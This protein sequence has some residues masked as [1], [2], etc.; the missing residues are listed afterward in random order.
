MFKKELADVLK[1]TGW[2]L[3][4][5]GL[6]PGPLILLH[7][8]SGS[9]LGV[10]VSVFQEGLSV[11]SLF[12]GAS[13]FG[14]ERRQR[15][16]EYPLSFPYSRYS[17]LARLV[18]P[19]LI[20]LIALIITAWLIN[21]RWGVGAFAL[22]PLAMAIVY[23]LPLFLISLSLSTLIENFIAL[24]LISLIGWCG[25]G[26]AIFRLLWGQRVTVDI[27][28][29]PVFAV[30][31]PGPGF[32]NTYRPITIFFLQII[33]PLIPFIFAL[34]ISFSRFDIRRSAAFVKRYFMAFVSSS[35]L[36]ALIALIGQATIN[37]T[38]RVFHLTKDLK[39]VEW[40]E[41]LKIIRIHENGSTR[42]TLLDSPILRRPCDD[43][44]FLY[45]QDNN[46]N[47]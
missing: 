47:L 18:G 23:Y 13:L 16:M 36:C 14:R 22:H 33:L 31:K 45:F 42:K 5:I 30:M 8:V 34:L 19:R 38:G 10:L 32:F 15:A 21:L 6:L 29:S 4:A 20:V 26:W 44:A 40:M 35:I 27:L 41:N 3:V 46:G 17:L 28:L 1:Q 11:W 39:L 43:N 25:S 2:F 7:W 9:Y 12:L 24:S 37:P